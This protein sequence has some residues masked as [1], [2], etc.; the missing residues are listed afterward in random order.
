MGRGKGGRQ[1]GCDGLEGGR[2][3]PTIPVEGELTGV[4]LRKKWSL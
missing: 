2:G 4:K 3:M 1:K